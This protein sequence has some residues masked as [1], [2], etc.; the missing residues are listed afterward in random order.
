MIKLVGLISPVIVP[1][2]V[3]G[4]L[5]FSSEKNNKPKL[6]LAAY[7]LLIT[8]IFAANFY[9]FEHNYRV[10]I[11][12]H[13]LHIGTVLAIYPGAFVYIKLLVS[14]ENQTKKLFLHFIPS[15]F[16]F[17]ASA[18][19]FFPFLSVEEREIFLT[20][21]RFQPDFSKIW[22]KILYYV[23]M[24]NIMVLF[25]QVF[26][27]LVLTLRTLKKHRKTMADIFSN[28]ERFQLNWLRYFN[29]ALALSA[30]VAVFLYAVNPARLFGDDRYLAYPLLLIAVILWFLGIM[31]NNQS[32]LPETA[33]E[34]EPES[35]SPAKQNSVLVK[36][37]L[38]YFEDKK[39]YLDPE[40]K[41]WDVCKEL[42]SNRTYISRMINTEFNK[43]F[44]GFVN[45]YRIQE[46]KRLIEK[47]PDTDILSISD[48]VG[49]GSVSSFNR[50]FSESFHMNMS[51]YRKRISQKG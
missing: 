28:P 51:E 1:L 21:Y 20:E 4:L 26:F 2:V 25:I 16:F 47:N 48:E 6:F 5:I 33:L 29:I 44:S 15:L 38:S 50:C 19:I 18:S 10:Y 7:M 24:A 30:F 32:G 14:P 37:L 22:M 36:K 42:G 27:Y 41:I 12:L 43:N 35:P 31:G 11:W 45:S 8:F 23:R 17:I 46:A 3:S 40:L 49:F 9:Y 39:P 13:S 34:R